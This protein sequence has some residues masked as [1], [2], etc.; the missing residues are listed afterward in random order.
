[1]APAWLEEGGFKLQADSM[2]VAVGPHELPAAV[3]A[4]G[5]IAGSRLDP[6]AHDIFLVYENAHVGPKAGVQ[7]QEK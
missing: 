7:A 3:S 5:G 2:I 6:S 4:S 1:M